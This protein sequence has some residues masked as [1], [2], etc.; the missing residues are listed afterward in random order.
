M[1]ANKNVSANRGEFGAA[2]EPEG[3]ATEAQGY[4]R[5]PGEPLSA[6]K[7]VERLGPDFLKALVQTLIVQSAINASSV[8]A[9]V[10][11]M[12]QYGPVLRRA[13]TPPEEQPISPRSD[14]KHLR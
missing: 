13:L 12:G 5:W 3:F 14:K 10:A 11:P 4:A 2:P 6:E 1:P 7:A 9:H 8:V